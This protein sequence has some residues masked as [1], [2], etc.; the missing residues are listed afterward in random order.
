ML[1]V[2][3]ALFFT[4][5][6]A[7]S[8]KFDD[9]AISGWWSQCNFDNY[10]PDPPCQ[11]S[12]V[13]TSA[14]VPLDSSGNT[15]YVNPVA[16]FNSVAW[17]GTLSAD[18]VNATYGLNDGAVYLFS[19]GL[20]ELNATQYLPTN[21]T[22]GACSCESVEALRVGWQDNVQMCPHGGCYS[23]GI[24]LM[25]SLKEEEC[26]LTHSFVITDGG[27]EHGRVLANETGNEIEKGN[28]WMLASLVDTSKSEG[29]KEPTETPSSIPT[30]SGPSRWRS[31]AAATIIAFIFAGW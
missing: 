22:D 16:N 13:P 12:L 18:A 28:C 26:S 20:E 31:I 10:W 14:L 25:D 4:F 23:S 21:C 6:F 15:C 19:I 9:L 1:R 5:Q 2:L 11:G 24:A 30:S 8:D 29:V 27:L 17:F 7:T 3:F